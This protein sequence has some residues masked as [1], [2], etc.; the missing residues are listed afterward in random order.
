V[1]AELPP[2]DPKHSRCSAKINVLE[3]TSLHGGPV[4]FATIR[5]PPPPHDDV[6]AAADER[7][8]RRR[9]RD[10]VTKERE[11]RD[12]LAS[13][14]R[15]V[16]ARGPWIESHPLFRGGRAND[17]GDEGSS[18]ASEEEEEEV[19]ED[20]GFTGGATG[21]HSVP[22]YD[23]RCYKI[24][25]YCY[26]G[27][28]V[29]EGRSS[30]IECVSGMIFPSSAPSLAYLKSSRTSSSLDEAETFTPPSRRKRS[31][32]A[33]SSLQI[34]AVVFGGRR[35]SFLSGGGLWDT[36]HSRAAA[37]A[38]DNFRSISI[39]R[40]TNER[41]MT[42]HPYLEVSDWIHDIRMLNVDHFY[43]SSE[44][45][46]QAKDDIDSKNAERTP[47]T[48]MAFLMAM[49]MTSNCCEIWAFRSTR[50]EIGRDVA[51]CPTRLL[52]IACDVR[53][54]TYS[55][56]L[57][58]W[59]DDVKLDV[60][61]CATN[62][63]EYFR[64]YG[65]VIVPALLAAS[66]TVFG[67]II[68]WGVVDVHRK[69]CPA[70]N[71]HFP[72]IFNSWLSD[73]ITE[74]NMDVRQ[75]TPT[76]I[77]VSP[78]YRLKGHLG[79]VFK[80]KFSECG[81]FLA[82]SSDDRTVR[83]WMLTATNFQSANTVEYDKNSQNI[84]QRSAT[85]ILAL[86]SS[87]MLYTLTWTGWGHTARVWDV[88]FVP[89]QSQHETDAL[90]PMIVS[91][92]EDGTARVWSPLSST[93]EIAHPLRGHRCESIWTVD[94]CEDIVV[95]GGNDGCVKL[96]G[97]GSRVRSG[98]ESV[99]SVFV[100]RDP[101]QN[102]PV[103]VTNGVDD[104]NSH[105]K[106]K[107]EN[108]QHEIGQTICGM[109]FYTRSGGVQTDL[110][111][112]T[113][114]GGLFSLD[115]TSNAWS[116]H[117]SW[118][119]HV[120]S[121][122]VDERIYIDPSTGNC[123]GAHPSGKCAVV[124]TTE[125]WLVISSVSGSS[126]FAAQTL[127]LNHNNTNV[128]FRAQSYFPVQSIT[129][130]D[131]S[132]LLVFYARGAIIWFRFD[133]SPTPLYVMNLG[134]TAIPLSF[135]NNS[136]EM[137]IG[138]SRGNI[139]YFS[140]NETGTLT[141]ID[142]QADDVHER[143]PNVLLT[144]VHGKEHVT[145]LVIISTGL[146]L[147]VGNDGCLHQCKRVANGE[148]QKLTSIPVPKVTGLRHIWT[149]ADA[150]GIERVILGGYYGNDFVM[151]DSTNGYYEL[152]RIATGGRQRR[153]DMFYS[154]N[155][156]TG[157]TRCTNLFGM[158]ILIGQKDGVN[159]IDIHC[160]QLLQNPL[161]NMDVCCQSRAIY[162]IGPSIHGEAIN[163]AC[164]VDD[165]RGNNFLLTGSN[166]CS[167]TLSK[168]KN[169]K[170]DSTV[171][172]PPHE[173]CVRGVCSSGRLLVTCGGKLSMEFYI[174]CT[175]PMLSVNGG[176]PSPGFVSLLCS[177]RTLGKAT[178]DHRMNSVRATNLFPPEKQCHLVLAGDSDGDLHL[179]I[180]SE[181]A[182][183]RRTVIGRKLNGNRRPIL[184]LALLRC[185]P[186]EI[187]AFVG[188]TDGEIS[189]WVLPGIILCDGDGTHELD[190]IIP[191]AP[192]HSFKAHKTGVNDISVAN[193]SPQKLT[194]TL[195]VVITSVGDDQ[196]LTTC[197]LEFIT[198]PR[199]GDLEV[200]SEIALCTTCASA[201]ALK[202]VK[203][204]SDSDFYRIYTIHSAEITL[205]HL[206]VNHHELSVNY[207]TSTP[208]GTEGSCIDCISQKST[209]G[210]VHDT[211]AVCGEGIALLSLNSNILRAFW[212]SRNNPAR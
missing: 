77:R 120:V 78:L 53:C 212:L 54:M 170:L 141:D 88:S 4:T 181:R 182:V 154:S 104:T 31:S 32:V 165:G 174:L 35:M 149:V 60:D 34:S 47:C 52:C 44:T 191:I 200:S 107:N 163:D 66:G 198:D 84:R 136:N 42:T 209:N 158:A 109:V 197:M 147:S 119:E 184:C 135:A 87:R 196:A 153:Q 162:S 11:Y 183:A 6:A 185:N 15:V 19:T 164:W 73:T 33:S 116:E 96:F 142:T 5:F 155:N 22:S 93:K 85:E 14:G 173:S 50:E 37:A 24:L 46:S 203:I 63:S 137:Y 190:G 176:D 43:R 194:D 127:P 80:V 145:G 72:S 180:I 97:L 10:D 166:D 211:I 144:N 28:N 61:G 202:A 16:F 152:L 117:S 21:G 188:T 25:A 58:G 160:S 128:A 75:N 161:E 199:E 100:P 178:I 110:L 67:D 133:E 20:G 98:E 101:R 7:R 114:A 112:V 18:A 103:I 95:T 129:F 122:F 83:L 193:A 156:N 148:L 49:A 143:K 175:S 111:V 113:R 102:M 26:G 57:Y 108:K 56:S 69:C 79:S 124:G 36:S 150:S 206:V 172:L 115:M 121:S 151:L 187:F 179:C 195:A 76:R 94:I 159:S 189:V 2:N 70:F 1:D 45:A 168:L 13:R 62:D 71:E 59:D 157:S 39:R 210:S 40:V 30:T 186:R 51:L 8:R 167:V 90:F 23:P 146:V 41:K 131:E 99:R 208:L 68:V 123:V 91:A 82:S 132:S 139:A 177:Y 3:R 171:E 207:I 29:V 106:K 48:T 204:I 126:S 17:E 12:L 92:G 27:S 89:L 86:D 169:C 201:T 125:G 38:A 81:N 138:D 192:V 118:S 74:K 105:R 205:W 9:G 65:S 64:S 140:L 55:L 130:I 134:T